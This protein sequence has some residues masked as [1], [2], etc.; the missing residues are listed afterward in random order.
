MKKFYRNTIDLSLTP[1]PIER[2][3]NISKEIIKHSDY[4]PKTLTYE[5]IDKS[6]KE[7][8]EEKIEIIQ[9]GLK[10]PTLVLYSNQRFSE[11]MQSWKYTDENNNIRLNFKTIT[12][13]NNPSHGT[14]MNDT[15]NIPGDRYYTLKRVQ[16]IN[17]VGKRYRIDYKMKQPTPVDLNY[18]VS[19]MT[20]KYT[21][22]NKFN[23]IV[24]RLFNSKQCYICP[25]GHY[26][27]MVLE[28]ISD[29]SEY[30]I[31]DRQF[32]S[33]NFNVKIR[34]YL[35]TE[36]DFRI[37][38][39]PIVTMICFEGDDAKR[40]KPT[41]E[42]SEYDPCYIEEEK[43]FKKPI[44]IDI[45]LSFCDPCLGK[46]KFTM[47]EDFI[48]TGIVLKNAFENDKELPPNII[49]DEI[50]LYV[51]G[52]IITDDLFNNAFEGYTKVENETE[53]LY[54]DD[55]I[56]YDVL[57]TKR[58]KIYKYIKYN[59]D[60]YVWHQIHF[61]DGDDIVLKTKRTSKYKKTGGLILKGYNRFIT[62]PYYKEQPE[63]KIDEDNTP[64]DY[65]NIFIDPSAKCDVD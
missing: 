41:I 27:S 43:Y 46:I 18:K 14:I 17:E 32:F 59:G 24:N 4:L 23:E 65:T 5:D 33:Q 45:D 10:L 13:E 6:F 11:Y 25:N 12:R 42:L 20:N 26:L 44:D 19:I 30:D 2:R 62:Y 56:E 36:E 28:N 31:E 64:P 53:D 37:E 55:T 39:N 63:T 49:Q 1:D 7:W 35:I 54:K 15:Y 29:E 48:L 9:D 57:P 3:H 52:E 34:A 61:S 47:D 8:V 38:E 22:I 50:S 40:S 60:Y 16:A 58:D 21:S 51:N